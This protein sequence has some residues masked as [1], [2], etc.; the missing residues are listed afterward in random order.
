MPDRD[1]GLAVVRQREQTRELV[2]DGV[3]RRDRRRGRPCAR[4]PAFRLRAR[5]RRRRSRRWCASRGRRARACAPRRAWRAIA[6]RS[7]DSA[8]PMWLLT[9][10]A[11]GTASSACR[12]ASRISS[13]FI[14][15]VSAPGP[16]FSPRC[17]PSA[18]GRAPPRRARPAARRPPRSWSRTAARRRSSGTPKARSSSITS[19]LRPRSSMTMAT[20]AAPS[21]RRQ[22]AAA[23]P[24]RRGGRLTPGHL[25]DGPPSARLS[26]GVGRRQ[27][28]LPRRARR[29][30]RAS[31]LLLGAACD[32]P[33]ADAAVRAPASEHEADADQRDRDQ[34][35]HARA[36]P[37]PPP[38][39]ARQPPTER[40]A[41]SSAARRERARRERTMLALVPTPP[42]FR[43]RRSDRAGRRGRARG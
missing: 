25:R 2:A 19:R 11:P 10:T 14:A 1:R 41:A 26:A 24:A 28:R 4:R 9:P 8:E 16:G 33:A 21:R 35:Q 12:V 20:G 22:L 29:P 5:A 3:G 23:A 31:R 17:A 18:G 42:S 7:S 40:R 43:R 34:R 30:K 37:P 36:R 38:P 27:R 32:R 39:P 13:W 6:S 15:S